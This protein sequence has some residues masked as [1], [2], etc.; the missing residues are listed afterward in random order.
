VLTPL[1]ESSLWREGDRQAGLCCLVSIKID[2]AATAEPDDSTTNIN[3]AHKAA[4][5]RNQLTPRTLP[6]RIGSRPNDL[7]S[8]RMGAIC[9]PSG[10]AT[11]QY[12]ARW[13]RLHPREVAGWARQPSRTVEHEV[14]NSVVVVIANVPDR[15]GRSWGFVAAP[16][17]R[18]RGSFGGHL[19]TVGPRRPPATRS[20]L[21]PERASER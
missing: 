4:E 21:H 17:S 10:L 15:P 6:R 7:R 1:V 18:L 14:R 16:P 12:R 13:E 9:S 19:R 5:T 20:I 3:A 11:R 8:A 2:L